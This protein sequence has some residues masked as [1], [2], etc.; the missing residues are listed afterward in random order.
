MKGVAQASKLQSQYLN[1]GHLAAKIHISNCWPFHLTH[2]GQ[3]HLPVNYLGLLFLT[4][5]IALNTPPM[6]ALG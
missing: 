1:V 6:L 3:V 4:N 5:S 2:L